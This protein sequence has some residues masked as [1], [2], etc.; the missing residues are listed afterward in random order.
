MG[1]KYY[2]SYRFP[3][4]CE[5]PVT[6]ENA[7]DGVIPLIELDPENFPRECA[8]TWGLL[9]KGLTKGVFQ[10]ESPLGKQWTKK[11][12]PES[13]EHMSALGAILRPGCLRAV[14]SEG[15]SMT[16]HYCRRKNGREE[17]AAYHPAVDA[18]LFPTYGVLVY[19]EQAMALAVA[20]AGFNEKEADSLRKAIGKKLAD[21]MVKVKAMFIEGVKKAGV[22]SEEMGAEVFGWIEESQRYSFNRSHSYCYGETGYDCA[23]I[24]THTPIAFFV[25]WLDQAKQKQDPKEE[26]F[27]LVNE[28]KL[29][30][31]DVTV[32]DLRELTPDFHSSDRKSIRFGLADIKGIGPAQLE[33]LQA[34]ILSAVESLGKPTGQWT[35][36]EFVMFAMESMGSNVVERLI[37]VGALSWFGMTRQK[38]LAEW[39]AWMELTER[40]QQ[41][42]RQL[43]GIGMGWYEPEDMTEKPQ[44][45][46]WWLAGE[47][48]EDDGTCG[49]DGA[50]DAFWLGPEASSS[51]NPEPSCEPSF[52]DQWAALTDKEKEKE[53]KKHQKAFDKKLEAHRLLCEAIKSVA[54]P[55]ATLSAALRVIALPKQ[56]GGIA[57]KKRQSTILGLAE[58]LDKPVQSMNDNPAWISWVEDDLLGISLS[59]SKIDSCDISQ[60]NCTCKEFLAGRDGFL[61]LGVEISRVRQITTKKGK[62]PGS[63]MAFLTVTDGSCSLEDVVVF[64]DVWKQFSHLIV[65]G[66]T[67]ILHGDRNENKDQVM[68]AVKKVWEAKSATA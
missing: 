18:V 4:G 10:L 45:K 30:D 66:N 5:W 57:T 25:S 38:M 8:A 37:K 59:C 49:S 51:A 26:I 13:P 28:A 48:A 23:Y 12:M 40:E 24:K 21:E 2:G 61:M 54:G 3:C 46:P 16:A 39:S 11:L 34:T 55:F 62:T 31:I 1:D 50:D 6:E 43:Q 20:I 17:V 35:W 33:K 9:G 41:W 56:E 60:V 47:V 68:F 19:Q 58:L 27:E 32:P 63:K 36:I 15:V 64:P 53:T 52:E 44:N 42:A 29:F 14:D 65:E 7:P 22:V 67:L